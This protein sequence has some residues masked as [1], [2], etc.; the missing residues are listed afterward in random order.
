MSSTHS[1]ILELAKQAQDSSKPVEARRTALKHICALRGEPVALVD[2]VTEDELA[3][4]A[5][6][7]TVC[8]AAVPALRDLSLVDSLQALR[9]GRARRGMEQRRC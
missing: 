7:M 3:W 6:A 1:T 9:E 2:A 4:V 8:S 5:A